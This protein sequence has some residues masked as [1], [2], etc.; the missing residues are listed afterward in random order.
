[1]VNKPI[2]DKIQKRLRNFRKI[3]PHLEGNLLLSKCSNI[4]NFSPS[5]DSKSKNCCI[6]AVILRTLWKSEDMVIMLWVWAG[7]HMRALQFRN[8]FIYNR[9]LLRG[10]QIAPGLP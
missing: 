9:W 3:T 7:F 5:S 8:S 1:M 6:L 4:I 2:V 10:V